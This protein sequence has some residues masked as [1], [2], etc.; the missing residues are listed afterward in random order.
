MVCLSKQFREFRRCYYKS[1]GRWF[2]WYTLTGGG[3][4]VVTGSGLGRNISVDLS[5]YP[6]TTQM[7]ALLNARQNALTAGANISIVGD[8][9]NYTYSYTHPS[10]HI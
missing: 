1:G 9:I 3:S 6:T 2:E 8:T 4:A 7:N 10:T 5:C